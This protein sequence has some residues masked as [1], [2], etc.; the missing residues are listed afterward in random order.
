MYRIES[1]K[2]A[3]P[4]KVNDRN[5][6]A[7]GA[8]SPHAEV[9]ADATTARERASSEI[10]GSEERRC[11]T[12]QTGPEA[13]AR[14]EGDRGGGGRLS[15]PLRSAAQAGQ[16]AVRRSTRAAAERLGGRANP[17]ARGAEALRWGGPGD[18]ESA[19]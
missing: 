15:A 1:W 13:S 10:R 16:R 19:G 18:Q 14:E 7:G 6:S 11:Q 8:T 5:G 2:L 4:S 17:E 3:I 12:G 9:E